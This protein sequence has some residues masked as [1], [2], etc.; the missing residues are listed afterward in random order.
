[1]ELWRGDLLSPLIYDRL[2]KPNA[3]TVGDNLAVL[4]SWNSV[5]CDFYRILHRSR[6]PES[7]G[8]IHRSTIDETVSYN[9]DFIF[10]F[11]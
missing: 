6:I 8:W 2:R 10:H 7:D 9:Y 1:M 5:N 11:G 4:I 3:T